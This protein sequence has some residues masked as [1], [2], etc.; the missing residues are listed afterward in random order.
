M[1]TDWFPR[2]GAKVFM[3]FINKPLASLE[4]NII[5]EIYEF[6]VQKPI[7]R[8][9]RWF[10]WVD[11]FIVDRT[12]SKLA[13]LTLLW[14]RKLQAI[15]SGQ[16]QHYAMIMVAGVLTLILIGIILP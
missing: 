2:K 9:A 12:F 6:I 5:G 7:L 13:N 3:W 15:Q 4:V 8:M 1:D 11:T 14:S 10:K 16:I